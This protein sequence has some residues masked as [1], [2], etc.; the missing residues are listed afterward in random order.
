MGNRYFSDE[1]AIIGTVD[2]D[3]N[4]AGTVTTDE[5]DMSKWERVAFIVM[6]GALGTNATVDFAV[7]GGA[8]SSAGSQATAITGK[9]ITQLT[10]AGTDSDKQAVVE[11]SA[12]EVAAQALRYI[13][14][15]LVTATATSDSGVLVLGRP[16]HYGPASDA[17]LASVDEIVT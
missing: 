6:A 9:A 15:S 3:A 1:W 8:T 12:D 11:V 13:E 16:R 17:D 7:K 14:G 4:A 2:P 10:E 5:I